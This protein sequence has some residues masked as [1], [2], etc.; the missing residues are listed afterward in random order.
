MAAMKAVVLAIAIT[1]GLASCGSTS[2]ATAKPTSS[3]SPDPALVKA[4]QDLALKTNTRLTHD[5]DLERSANT[6]ADYDKAAKDRSQALHDYNDGLRAMIFPAWMKPHV[7][8]VLQDVV[9]MA[10][11]MDKASNAGTPSE[12]QQLNSSDWLP[13]LTDAQISIKQL[14]GD[15]GMQRAVVPDI[16]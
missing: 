11:A 4:Y 1:M 10:A 12:Y 2:T 8:A 15:L 3:P 16:V 14:R 7:D 5:L 9:K 6:A 13:A